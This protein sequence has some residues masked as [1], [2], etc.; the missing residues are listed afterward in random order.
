L[1]P[2]ARQAD[3][4]RARAER[5]KSTS[6]ETRSTFT[7]E[8]R[9]KFD[10]RVIEGMRTEIRTLAFRVADLDAQLEGALRLLDS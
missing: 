7:D 10:E 1:N 6:E 8:S 2:V 9:P 4:L 3:D 5:L